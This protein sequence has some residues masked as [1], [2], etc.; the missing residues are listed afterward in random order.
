[1]AEIHEKFSILDEGALYPNSW[2]IKAVRAKIQK[3]MDA[4]LK[5]HDDDVA[6]YTNWIEAGRPDL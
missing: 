2:Q 6:A 4:T 1:L 5:E 3:R